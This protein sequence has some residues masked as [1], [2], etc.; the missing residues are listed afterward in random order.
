MGA[1][2]RGWVRPAPS[3]SDSTALASPFCLESKGADKK[4]AAGGLIPDLEHH[5]PNP[6][7]EC[8]Q[9]QGAGLLLGTKSGML[10]FLSVL[11]GDGATDTPKA[12][13]PQVGPVRSAQGRQ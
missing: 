1:E 13:T 3:S 6:Q 8:C 11:A 4:E 2:A 7:G 5:L 9:N 12:E 10:A